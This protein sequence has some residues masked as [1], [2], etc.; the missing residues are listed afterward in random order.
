MKTGLMAGGIALLAT[1]G[2]SFAAFAGPS[3][4]TDGDGVYDVLD[5]CVNVPNAAP[6]D[7]DTDNDGYGNM[8]DGDFDQDYFIFPS[9]YTIWLG[10]AAGGYDT[11][12]TGTDMDCDG[13]VFPSDYTRWLG[14]AAIGSPGPSG[15]YCAGTV[16]C[17]L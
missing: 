4:D 9:D 1:L 5:N 6:Q 17:D 7:C 3:V 2:L 13:F 14:T 10:D 15:L 11:S 16:P 8:C 12:G